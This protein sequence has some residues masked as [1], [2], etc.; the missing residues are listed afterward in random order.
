MNW[1]VK[2]ITFVITIFLDS[3]G[4][5]LMENVRNARIE[6]SEYRG[7]RYNDSICPPKILPLK[8]ICRYNES[9]PVPVWW[10]IKSFFSLIYYKD[11]CCWYL[12]ESPRRG[13]SNKYQQ[14]MFLRVLNTVFLNISNYLSHL[15]LRNRSIQ[16]VVISNFAVIS[17][18]GIK[19]FNC[20]SS[21]IEIRARVG[22]P[23]ST[24]NGKT[25]PQV[26][27][28]TIHRRWTVGGV[29]LNAVWDACWCCIIKKT[30]PNR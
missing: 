28:R 9:Q 13:D 26:L 12:L 1:H 7:T 6:D 27:V 4:L 22:Q 21:A 23:Y 17:N 10:M 8:R 3:L 5:V 11:K 15:E 29:S 18:V 25:L 2:E 24:P 20:I 14:H 16:L 19:K 30:F